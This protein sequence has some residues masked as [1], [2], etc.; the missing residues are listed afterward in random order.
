MNTMLQ[1]QNLGNAFPFLPAD[2]QTRRKI[3]VR[4]EPLR[5]ALL[6]GDYGPDVR[7]DRCCFST[8]TTRTHT[9]ILQVWGGLILT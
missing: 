1:H 2:L 5:P 6:R 4:T 8:L 9:C 7:V 3:D